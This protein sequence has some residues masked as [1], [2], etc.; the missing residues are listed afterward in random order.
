MRYKGISK[1]ISETLFE[2][3]NNRLSAPV[4]AA[5]LT[6]FRHERAVHLCITL[7]FA[8][9]TII[10]Y[11][12]LAAFETFALLPAAILITILTACYIAYYFFVENSTQKLQELYLNLSE[13]EIET[14]E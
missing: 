5:R 1:L 6:V 7:A 2:A 12:F 10:C 8:T 14:N 13:K 3:E 9:W 11:A 4:L